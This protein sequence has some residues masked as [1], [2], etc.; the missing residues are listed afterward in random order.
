MRAV[1]I[2]E[3]K[4]DKYELSKNE[5]EFLFNGYN[6]S[7]IPDYQMSAFL[8]AGYLNGFSAKESF[9]MT[10]IMR[11]S[12]EL[13][14]IDCNNN[15]ILDK[16]STGGV[17]DKT[18]LILAPIFASFN[19]AN[20]K[21]SG[22]GLGH[23]GG[24][25]D[26]FEAIPGFKFPENKEELK[27]VFD[28]SGIGIMGYSKDIVP[29]D[30]K[31]YAL[32]DVTGTVSNSALIASSVMSKKLAVK[33]DGIILDVKAGEGAFMSSVEKAR[34]LSDIMVKIAE[35]AGKKC[36]AIITNMDKPLGEYIG[37]GLEVI[38][39]IEY[40]KGR[41]SEDLREVIEEI[42]VLGLKISG[43][44]NNREHAIKKIR[45]MVAS[46]EPL[47]KFEKFIEICNGDISVINNYDLL[48]KGTKKKFII[49][50]KCGY[51]KE[52][53]AMEIGKASM[54]LGAGRVKKEDNIDYGAGIKII[55]KQGDFVNKGD[56]IAEIYY[57]N[58]KTEEAEKIIKTSYIYSENISQK[59]DMV[60]EIRG[61]LVGN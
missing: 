27:K 22:R 42:L 6:N 55:K 61:G 17:G 36:V 35:L 53:K 4:R 8:M 23:T 39:A 54:I 40:L 20:I 30:K 28:Y 58:E 2:I 45:D 59:I 41:S 50:E 11:D 33:S 18:T 7:D 51:I 1:D 49:A 60:I 44:E 38:E 5:L 25:V 10:E 16:H 31:V 19:I 57:K 46:K 43:I 15:F 24:T 56:I 37:N 13:I 48:L 3:K 9:Y 14:D 21:L 26:K 52:L 12:G 32:R 47:K 29:L 34:E